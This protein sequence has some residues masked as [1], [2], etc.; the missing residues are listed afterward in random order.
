VTAQEA[1]L[2][3]AELDAALGVGNGSSSEG[4][5][6]GRT[7]VTQVDPELLGELNKHLALLGRPGVTAADLKPPPTPE[8]LAAHESKVVE[9]MGGPVELDANE[10]AWRKFKDAR[11]D[12]VA[13][14]NRSA[15]VCPW[16]VERIGPDEPVA[17]V[18]EWS[19]YS[20]DGV[21]AVTVHHTC[22]LGAAFAGVC[23]TIERWSEFDWYVNMP[24]QQRAV[25]HKHLLVDELS[26][27]LWG[28]ESLRHLVAKGLMVLECRGC[29]RELHSV[30]PY[31]SERCRGRTRRARRQQTTKVCPVCEVEFTP[32]RKD[33][34]TCSGACRQEQHRRRK[35]D[36]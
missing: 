19:A 8:R 32:K 12:I 9:L 2:A 17:F 27:L 5:R 26:D 14:S 4:S 16:C 18:K 21:W 25:R 11:T 7:A 23:R 22:W 1:R 6:S 36:G 3:L 30:R 10:L 33:A 15:S 24:E 29:G 13:E 34:V 35:R 31:C 28:R 20:G